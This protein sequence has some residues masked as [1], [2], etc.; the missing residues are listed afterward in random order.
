MRL[1][2]VALC[3]LSLAFAAPA[4]ADSR[5]RCGTV[6]GAIA[7][8]DIRTKDVSCKW[9]RKTARAWRKALLADE[10]VDGRFRC[11]V[12]GYV[13]RAKPPAEVHYPVTCKKN[14]KRVR[15]EIHAD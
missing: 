12:R 6:S 2:C 1:S 7:L 13:C 9:A 10:C 3:L 5:Q 11:D 8:Y 4:A 14:A 15:W